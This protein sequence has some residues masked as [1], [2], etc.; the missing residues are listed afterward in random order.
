MFN[1]FFSANRALYGMWKNIAERARTQM[2]H[3]HYVLDT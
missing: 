2:A 3:A 1:N